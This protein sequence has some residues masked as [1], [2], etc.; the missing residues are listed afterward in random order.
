LSQDGRRDGTRLRE[1]TESGIY[2]KGPVLTNLSAG[3]AKPQMQMRQDGLSAASPL[4]LWLLITLVLA[5]GLIL[6]YTRALE[7]W[8]KGTFFDPDDAMRLV[9]VRDFLH[10]QTW[11]DM[12]AYRLDPPAGVFMHWSRIIDVPLA[13]LIKFFG[14]ILPPDLA[15]RASRL[16]F[17]LA[18]QALLCLGIARLA[19]VLIG[20]AAIL[21]ALI[22]TL[23]SGMEFSQ[24]QPGR[25]HH[26]APQIMLVIFML[27]SFLE[28][29]DPRKARHAAIAGALGALCLGIGLES[30][31][32]IVTLCGLA[33]AL[34]I[35]RGAELQ[36]TLGFFALGLGL[37]LPLVFLATIGRAHWFD[38]V[39]DAYS[40]AYFVPGI[41]GAIVL[42]SLAA[43]SQRLATLSARMG[44][45]ACAAAIVVGAAFAIKPI[46]FI[47]PYH[48]IDPLLRQIWLNNVIEGFPLRRLF[49]QDAGTAAMLA[50]PI[51][52]GSC[53][54]L[55]ALARATGLARQRW[56]IVC[57]MSLVGAALSVWMIRMTSFAALISLFGG[58]WCIIAVHDT[59]ARTKWRE[60][61][62]LSF[63]L[64]LPFSTVGWALAIPSKPDDA[65]HDN[66]GCLA[67]AAFTPLAELPPGIVVA[68][69]DAGAHML[70][71]TPH[72]V[73]AAPYHRDN[74]GNRVMLDAMLATPEDARNI[75]MAHHTTYVMTC[76]GMKDFNML[77]ARAPHGLA[78]ALIAGHAPDWL[79]P[80]SNSGAYHVFVIQ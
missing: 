58:A 35:F 31:P 4:P 36:R 20:P 47:D 39:C 79:K 75:L 76:A 67:S 44:A 80:L 13:I 16:I 1:S 38:V 54:S 33:V 28:A 26:S 51:C 27:A 72:N 5:L 14:L 50:L 60:I 52:L 55:V 24:F 61:A 77:A 46:C 42:A 8:T 23:L 11:F 32:F 45:A 3:V 56:L 43:A 9:E 6:S 12:T 10:G 65:E 17:P 78:A 18:L 59:L 30:L 29:L 62:A 74:I 21:P 49:A 25:I 64:A 69:I 34:W 66:S 37:A 2:A 41:V 71:F 63:C 70:V 53:A 68:P 73:L 7:V 22:L 15:E 40:P 19:K 48:G 57:V